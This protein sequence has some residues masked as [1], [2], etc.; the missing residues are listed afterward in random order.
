MEEL[1]HGAA[2]FALYVIPAGVIMLT[3]RRLIWIPDELF[4]KILH[5]ILLGAYLPLLYAFNTWWLAVSFVLALILLLYPVLALAGKIPAFSTFV[6]E[7]KE[8]EFKGSMVLALLTMAGSISVCW[9][10]FGDRLLVLACVYAWGIGDAFAA[11][12]GK[13]WGKHKIRFRWADRHK[14]VEGSAAM[15]VCGVVTVLTILLLRGGLPLGFCVAVA[16]AVAAA[17]TFVELC[18]KGGMDTITCPAAAMVVI[19]PS[20]MW[21]GA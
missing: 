7:R 9:G 17:T 19:L 6:N 20:V 15:F 10:F 18:S 12:V 4:R 3:L 2:V 8:G 16:L 11:L 5:W 13:K 1:Y 14:S 21:M